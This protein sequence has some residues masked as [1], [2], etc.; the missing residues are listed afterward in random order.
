MAKK[1]IKTRNGGTMTE[2]QYFGKLRSSL[3]RSFRWWIPMKQA[4]DAAKRTSENKTNKRLKFEYQCAKCGNWFPRSGVEI[5]HIEPC[6]SLLSL[7]DL[8]EF[9]EKLTPENPDAYQVL[10]KDDHKQKTQEE[11]T[12]R[13]KQNSLQ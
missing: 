2:A 4:L 10:C 6:G 1:V 9:V 13:R 3:R 8:V 7:T 12:N 11:A 5:D